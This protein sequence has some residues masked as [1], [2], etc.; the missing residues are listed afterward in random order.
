[1]ICLNAVSCYQYA[2][3]LVYMHLK[4]Q[5]LCQGYA[6]KQGMRQKG[7]RWEEMFWGKEKEGRVGVWEGG[8]GTGAKGKRTV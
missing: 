7:E 4:F 2:R 8:K 5:K 3:K 6:I 1:M